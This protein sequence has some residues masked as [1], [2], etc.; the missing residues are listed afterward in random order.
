MG[1]MHDIASRISQLIATQLWA[2]LEGAIARV[3]A[4]TDQVF[5]GKG[6][7]EG[8]ADVFLD[9]FDKAVDATEIVNIMPV[10]NII[11]AILGFI[12]RKEKYEEDQEQT[13]TK[14]EMT[15]F[16]ASY[17][18]WWTD[19]NGEQTIEALV[20]EC[21]HRFE[22]NK[23]SVGEYFSTLH[24]AVLQLEEFRRNLRDYSKTSAEA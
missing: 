18:E 10:F 9:A 21:E 8:V 13:W 24:D 1:T 7:P 20:Q 5:H 22:A 4:G 16:L 12:R 17:F 14:F 23:K 19:G 2:F 6:M 15:V 11:R 3:A